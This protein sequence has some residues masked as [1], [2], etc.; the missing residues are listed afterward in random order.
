MPSYLA[1]LCAVVILCTGCSPNPSGDDDASGDDDVTGDD[2]STAGDDDVADD[3]STADDDDVTSDDDTDAGCAETD[4]CDLAQW[5]DVG[6]GDC[7]QDDYAC[8][9]CQND[10]VC[11]P[12]PNDCVYMGKG[13]FCGIDC[14]EDLECPSGLECSP[15]KDVSGN[16]LGR[17]CAGPCWQLPT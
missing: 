12:D 3:D 11:G 1:G 13:S 8:V 6:S 14:S 5:C 17:L 15:V 9:P 2:D 4:D 10:N 16:V 7:Y